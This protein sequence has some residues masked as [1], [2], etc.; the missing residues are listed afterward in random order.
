MSVG[1]LVVAATLFAVIVAPISGAADGSREVLARIALGSSATPVPKLAGKAMAWLRTSG[2]LPLPDEGADFDLRVGPR[3]T[4]VTPTGGE[5]ANW[6]GEI[7]VGGTY[8]SVVGKWTVPAVVPS[9]TPEVASSWVGIGGDG[10]TELIQVGTDSVSIAGSTTYVAWF[11]LLPATAVTIPEPVSPGDAMAATIEETSTDRWVVSIEDLTKGWTVTKAFSYTAGSA[12]SAEWITERPYTARTRRLVT[13][14]DFGSVRFHDLRANGVVVPTTALAAVEMANPT[15]QVVA[16]PGKVT[17][18]TTGSF[19]AYYGAPST[20]TPSPPGVTPAPTAAPTVTSV[21]PSSGP[22]A[23][24][25]IV[26][27]VGSNF[28]AGATVRFGSAAATDVAVVSASKIMATSPA[29]TAGSVRVMVTTPNGT[30][31]ATSADLFEYLAPKVTSVSLHEGPTAGGTIV[32][33]VGSNFA[34]G[35][36]VR[37]GTKPAARV[38]VVSATRITATSPAHGAGSVRVIVTI[39]GGTSIATSADLFEYLAPKVTSV[40][41]HEGPTAGG[42]VVTIT[43]ADFVRGATVRFGTKPAAHVTVVS[44]TRITATSPAHGAGSV[45]VTVTI[46]GG[47]SLATP[48]DDFRYLA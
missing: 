23:G 31:L 38:T 22:T 47:T 15:G 4:D 1:A 11:E 14:A 9:S 12:S 34:A 2:G 26:T 43:G 39:P 28:A 18:T 48:A 30:S 42:T 33:I 17:S 3:Q 6:A 45:R 41:R 10:I 21:L 44:A 35:A 37:F 27:I 36:T 7:D 46:P 29:R 16:F 8:T 32:T 24:G 19:T 25:T 5:S 40:S 20:S 13:L